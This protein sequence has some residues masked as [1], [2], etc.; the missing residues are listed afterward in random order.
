MINF[1]KAIIKKVFVK[2]GLELNRF[3][4]D[5]SPDAQL[6]FSLYKFDIDLIFDVGAN[7]GQFASAVMRGG[8]K[9]KIVSFEPLTS[10]HSL[11]LKASRR[12]T[13]WVVHPRCAIG[14]HDGKATIN[15]AGNSASSS[16]LPMLDSHISAA[17]HTAYIGKETVTLS[18][19]DTIAPEYL[20]NIKMAV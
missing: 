6:I 3:K 13:N 10:A 18:K 8:F 4:P 2:M 9:G 14:D 7:S 12:D 20:K 1:S 17:P 5:S 16:L 15:I 11:L 19:L